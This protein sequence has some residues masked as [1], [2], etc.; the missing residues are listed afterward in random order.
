MIMYEPTKHAFFCTGESLTEP[1]HMESCDI[2]TMVRNAAR[3]L[4]V[5]GGPQ[6]VFGYDDTT[7]DGVQFRIQKEALEK[8]LQASAKNEIEPQFADFIPESVKK[9]FGFKTKQAK[10]VEEQLPLTPPGPP[11][12][13]PTPKP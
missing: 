7:M 10:P 5:R 6:P 2:N 12:T 3:G 13:E 9:K 11:S 8:E 4:Q 1:E